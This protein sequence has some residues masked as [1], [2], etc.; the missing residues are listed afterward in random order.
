MSPPTRAATSRW[1]SAVTCWYRA[2]ID[3]LDQP[4]TLMTVRSG[5]P[6]NSTTVAAVSRAVQPTVPQ[7]GELEK[8]LPLVVVGLGVDRLAQRRGE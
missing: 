8:T 2:A 3:V 4:M 6:S 7:A 5:T 1:I